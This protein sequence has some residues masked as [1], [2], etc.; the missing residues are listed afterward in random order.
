MNFHTLL[1]TNIGTTNSVVTD[2][3]DRYGPII[4]SVVSVVSLVTSVIPQA[5]RRAY[6]RQTNKCMHVQSIMSDYEKAK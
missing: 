6:D 4:T 1:L 2:I 5:T 3:T